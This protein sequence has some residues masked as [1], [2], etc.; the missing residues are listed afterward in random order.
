VLSANCLI[1]Q[2]QQ[3]LEY[4][5]LSAG[6]IVSGVIFV[7]LLDTVFNSFVCRVVVFKLW[8]LLYFFQMTLD[9]QYIDPGPGD[10]ACTNNRYFALNASSLEFLS[11]KPCYAKHNTAVVFSLFLS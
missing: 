2:Q 11:R 6:R 7:C 1:K 5:L 9:Y 10:P 3:Q 4:V 8:I